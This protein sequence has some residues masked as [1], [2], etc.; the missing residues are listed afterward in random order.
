M[1]GI[2]DSQSLGGKE[3]RMRATGRSKVENVALSTFC[4]GCTLGMARH[5]EV[6]LQVN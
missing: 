3:E 6:A 4:I 1:I 2:N 5:L